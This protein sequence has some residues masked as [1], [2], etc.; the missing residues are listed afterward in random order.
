[1][2]GFNIAEQ[3]HVVCLEPIDV[4]GVAKTVYMSMAN[5]R[6]ASVIVTSGTAA[7]QAVLTCFASTDGAGTGEHAIAFRSYNYGATDVAGPKVETATT[8]FTQTAAQ[9]VTIFE[10]DGAELT[11]D[12]PFLGIKTDNAAANIIGVVVVLSGAR[13]EAQLSPTVGKV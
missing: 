3:G 8:G 1:M 11:A 12:H 4:G 9:C 6:H 2:Q 13:Y 5:H 10:I 7:N